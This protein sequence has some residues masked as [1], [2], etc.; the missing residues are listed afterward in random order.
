MAPVT[1]VKAGNIVEM[2]LDEGSLGTF[3]DALAQSGLQERLASQGP[4]TVFAPTDD[5]FKEYADQTLKEVFS[6]KEELITLISYHIVPGKF[7]GSYFNRPSTVSTLLG[8][9]LVI[10]RSKF[11]EPDIECTN[12]VIHIIDSVMVPK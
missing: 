9:E 7:M 3:G 11:L 8:K 5:A 6:N 12:G 10:D 2:A 4:Y 1:M